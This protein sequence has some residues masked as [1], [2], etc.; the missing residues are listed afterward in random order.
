[1]NE[2]MFVKNKVVPV[3]NEAPRYEGTYTC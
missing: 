3:F 2:L 1:V